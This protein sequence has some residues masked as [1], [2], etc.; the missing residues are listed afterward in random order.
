MKTDM[1][2]IVGVMIAVILAGGLFLWSQEKTADEILQSM[3]P[4]SYDMEATCSEKDGQYL[5]C[6]DGKVTLFLYDDI[7]VYV[8]KIDTVV[9]ENGDE[10]TTTTYK[11]S[12]VSNLEKA[13]E[14]NDAVLL[15]LWL[16]DHG[17]IESL[18]MVETSFTNHNETLKNLEGLDPSSYHGTNVVLSVD[19][20]G[21]K[22]APVNYTEAEKDKF[23]E[24]I[25]DY[26][27]AN[28]VRFYIGTV[29][30]TEGE[31]GSVLKNTQ[32]GKL[33]YDDIK[34]MDKL[35]TAHIWFNEDG[36]ITHVLVHKEVKK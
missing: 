23:K 33:T 22:L 31:D 15:H 26:T 3:D 18:M 35:M 30:H 32:Y 14:K 24:M 13:L 20:K 25:N 8:K 12:S 10:I 11:T 6:N 29:T 28:S 5:I 4:E 21:M 17:Q 19:K 34:D 9:K 16:T 2:V 1:K 27:F 7:D 36:K